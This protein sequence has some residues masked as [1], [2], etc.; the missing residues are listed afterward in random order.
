MNDAART[1]P[2]AAQVVAGVQRYSLANGLDVVLEER[3]GSPRVAVEVDY[4]VGSRDQPEGYGGLAHMTE[5][6][7]F[8]WA[9]HH[10]DGGGAYLDSLG[11]SQAVGETH[12]DVT[13]YG[14][15]V[16]SHFLERLLAFEADR[17]GFLL[18]HVG[19][20]QLEAQRLIVLREDS[21]RGEYWSVPGMGKRIWQTLFPRG[22]PYFGAYEDPSDIATLSLNSVRWFHQQWYV[23]SN[24]TLVI[25]GDFESSA[26]RAMVQRYFGGLAREPRPTRVSQANLPRI[27]T[28][29]DQQVIETTRVAN[30]RLW[31]LFP[32][33]RM[34][35]EG[36]A[37]LDL[38][39]LALVGDEFA[40]LCARLLR[41][42]VVDA[43]TA[44]QNSMELA[45]LFTISA[46]VR[47]N[48]SA[49]A[50]LAQI[51]RT[52]RESAEQL[53]EEAVAVARDR[54]IA[55]LRSYHS[56]LAGRAFYLGLYARTF[57]GSPDLLERDVARYRAASLGSVRRAIAQWL[58]RRSRVV[59]I[60][61][62]TH[63]SAA[64]WRQARMR[65][66]N[67]W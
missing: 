64:L 17:M 13:R 35:S 6:M 30:D 9:R 11:V 50:V 63:N 5:H 31:V 25:V 12:G 15:V 62:G 19:E 54:Q 29:G 48:S 14:A 60:A 43:V 51:D 27:P 52:L 40:P 53:T 58:T 37:E 65:P 66:E 23:P 47:R 59:A 22:H 3:H 16:A 55:A 4:R 56:T 21:E 38:A 18:S 7:M 46:L 39:A 28:I 42:R 8:A 33:P 44:S 32:T 67:L 34:F 10:R 57:A 20:A 2:P 49:E 36:D 45:S 61:R 41:D 26:V 24:A 1:Q